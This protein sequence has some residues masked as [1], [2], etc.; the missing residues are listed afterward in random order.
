MKKNIIK[1]L[2]SFT[3]IN[4]IKLPNLPIDSAPLKKLR[5]CCN[6]VKI[7]ISKNV[8]ESNNIKE[9]KSKFLLLT[10]KI[11]IIFNIILIKMIYLHYYLIH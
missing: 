1:Y 9:I 7:K 10:D 2:R 4:D 8:R 3:P 11:F 5:I 6:D